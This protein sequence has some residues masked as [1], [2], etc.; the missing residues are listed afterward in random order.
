MYTTI[1]YP[2][3]FSEA[4]RLKLFP[5]TLRDS[6]SEWLDTFPPQ[7]IT[8]WNSLSQKFLNKYFSSKMIAKLNSWTSN[9]I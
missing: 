5:Y 3:L 1:E 9:V 8:S 6:A 7:S 4:I 2:G